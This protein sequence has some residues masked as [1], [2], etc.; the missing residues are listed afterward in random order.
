MACLQM[1]KRGWEKKEEVTKIF[2]DYF[3][4]QL[5]FFKAKMLLIFVDSCV[6]VYGGKLNISQ[7]T[8]S[9]NI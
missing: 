4:C 6:G 8:N 9:G 2:A 3:D 1:E 5:I 7:M